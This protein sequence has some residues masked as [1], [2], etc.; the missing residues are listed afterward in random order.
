MDR[1]CSFGNKST[2][3]RLITILRSGK[4]SGWRRHIAL[5]GRP[6]FAFPRHASRFLS[7]AAFG[8]VVLA[9]TGDRSETRTWQPKLRRNQS[10]DRRAVGY[11]GQW[12]GWLSGFG[13][14]HCPG[15][16]AWRGG[17]SERSRLDKSATETCWR[18]RL[19][20]RDGRLSTNVRSVKRSASLLG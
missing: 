3:L 15:Q 10:R 16:R 7:M 9:I 11:C 14:T 2:E 13:S 12:V 5:P 8:M 1:I 4:I 19:R 6:D 17:L 18:L 20:R